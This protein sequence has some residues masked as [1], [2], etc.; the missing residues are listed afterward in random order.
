[1]LLL[2]QNAASSFEPLFYISNQTSLIVQT[3]LTFDSPSL[4]GA[5]RLYH[6]HWSLWV[7]RLCIKN[8]FDAVMLYQAWTKSMR[9]TRKKELYLCC[10]HA[11]WRV[12]SGLRAQTLMWLLLCSF[13]FIPLDGVS[14]SFVLL[15]WVVSRP[16]AAKKC[17]NVS[18]RSTFLPCSL[19]LCKAPWVLFP[20]V[21][22]QCCA[23]DLC[24]AQLFSPLIIR[25]LSY[26]KK[27]RRHR[28]EVK[29]IMW[30]SVCFL[31]LVFQW[32]ASQTNPLS[33]FIILCFVMQTENDYQ[34]LSLCHCFWAK[35]T[36]NPL[37]LWTVKIVSESTLNTHASCCIYSTTKQ[38]ETASRKTSHSRFPSPALSPFRK[39][40]Q[41]TCYRK[42][43]DYRLAVIWLC[44]LELHAEAITNKSIS[45][46]VINI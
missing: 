17:P 3:E 22:V 23:F 21:C 20:F 15:I 28:P 1:M 11:P 26:L 13:V 41:C 8:I 9:L 29:C 39:L 37:H 2:V 45:R 38:E 7:T 42:H 46:C 18:L 25:C 12:Q 35:S 16:C 36:H 43:S 14:C 32:E 30:S 19:G 34:L 10:C 5:S 4:W 33:P 31:L 40:E 24:C 6:W 27:A 44:F